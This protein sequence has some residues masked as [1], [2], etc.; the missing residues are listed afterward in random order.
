MDDEMKSLTDLSI[1]ESAPLPPYQRA[2]P[3][4]WVF[5]LKTGENGE[6]LRH[7]ARLVVCGFMQKK[8]Y[9]CR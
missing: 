4:K 5:K 2:I 3:V 1:F 9:R 8:G 7:K 6:V